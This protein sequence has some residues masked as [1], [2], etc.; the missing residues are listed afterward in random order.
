MDEMKAN[1]TC[2]DLFTQDV[3]QSREKLIINWIQNKVEAVEDK[4][5]CCRWSQGDW[6]KKSGD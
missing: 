1:E 6:R 4:I 2:K 5:N 3:K